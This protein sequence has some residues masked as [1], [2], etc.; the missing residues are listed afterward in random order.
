MIQRENASGGIRLHRSN[1]AQ[2]KLKEMADTDCIRQGD[3]RDQYPT[4]VDMLYRWGTVSVHGAKWDGSGS[5][6]LGYPSVQPMFKE[7][8]TGYRSSVDDVE[9]DEQE[10]AF[11]ERLI[12]HTEDFEI[13]LALL[14][15]YGERW[16]LSKTAKTFSSVRAREG[17]EKLDH[18]Q[19]SAYIG[20]AVA[21]IDQ[22][23]RLLGATLRSG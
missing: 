5:N 18:R 17:R 15:F 19:M 9:I 22:S 12:Q 14:W 7:S 10:V 8:T 23:R 20:R 16:S 21:M 2:R 1:N 4:A 13:R 3:W 11:T 6:G